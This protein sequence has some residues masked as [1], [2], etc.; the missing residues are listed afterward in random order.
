ML[1][2]V[3]AS[4]NSQ[5]RF[6]DYFG[7]DMLIQPENEI[8]RLQALRALGVLDTAAESCF[9]EIVRAA[10]LVC[11]VPISLISLVDEH[12]QWFKARVGLAAAQTPRD[13]AF[14]AY[15]ILSPDTMLEVSD[16]TKDQRFSENPLVTGDPNIRFYAGFPLSDVNGFSLGTLCV[17]DREP[18]VLDNWQREVLSTLARQVMRLLAARASARQLDVWHDQKERLT[19]M[20]QVQESVTRFDLVVSGAAMGIWETKFDPT[21]WESQITNNLPFYWSPRFAQMMGYDSSEFP[22]RLESWLSALHPDDRQPT[23]QS[24]YAFLA[25]G[26][27]YKV[28]YRLKN[29]NGEYR[30]YQSNGQA[31][32]DAQGRPIRAAGSMADITSRKRDQELLEKRRAQLIDAIANIDSGFAMYDEN[33]HLIIAN[34]RF[35]TLYGIELSSIPPN[36]PFSQVLASLKSSGVL[37][38][39]EDPD[40]WIRNQ[41]I[42]HKDPGSDHEYHFSKKLGA[43]QRAPHCR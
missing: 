12:R 31:E 21:C 17:I 7:H 43:N 38:T 8:N 6:M 2:E 19:M 32:R 15:T 9:D 10:A 40:G 42:N 39:I 24:I 13:I 28:D 36:T 37:H 4:G 5:S 30:W 22:P 26:L 33:D 11:K 35:A 18:R 23:L 14:C 3:S 27:P 41:I 34:Q 16:A 25:Q 20:E 29:K 1:I